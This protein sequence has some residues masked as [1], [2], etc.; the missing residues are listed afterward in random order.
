MTKQH[1]HDYI[2]VFFQN[3]YRLLIISALVCML[4]MLISILKGAEL[5]I[6]LLLGLVSF[7]FFF[8]GYA[9]PRFVL[10]IQHKN[11]YCPDRF[12][13]SAAQIFLYV[14]LL[15]VFIGPGQI[16]YG[17]FSSDPDELI[18]NSIP[19]LVGAVHGAVEFLNKIEKRN[20]KL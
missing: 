11:P 13:K 1:W 14:P 9:V 4:T 7:F 6:V 15:V 16:V 3:R 20:I 18:F 17:I 2:V 12:L 5:I 19:M 10:G 8:G